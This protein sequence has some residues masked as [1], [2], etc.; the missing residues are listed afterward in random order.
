MGE[1][2]EDNLTKGSVN[3][4]WFYFHIMVILLI[5]F[6]DA[7]Y[8]RIPLLAASRF[9]QSAYSITAKRT[10]HLSDTDKDILFHSGL[11]F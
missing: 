4:T 7:V 6:L 5:C 10:S 8:T 9:L 11:C 1:D 2:P 3:E